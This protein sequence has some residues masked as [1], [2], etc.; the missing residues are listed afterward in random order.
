M[1]LALARLSTLLRWAERQDLVELPEGNPC[2]GVELGALPK[3]EDYLRRD[4]VRRLLAFR[5]P[6]DLQELRTWAMVCVVLYEG[7][8]LGEVRILGRGAIDGAAGTLDVRWSWR[9]GQRPKSGKARL[10]PLHPRLR[11][12]LAQLPEDGEL[13]FPGPGG[14]AVSERGDASCDALRALCAR[15]GVRVLQPKPWH[16][17]RHTFATHLDAATGGNLVVSQAMLGH[18]RSGASAATQAYLHQQEL[19]YLAGELAKLTY[20][21]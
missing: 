19:S 11:E 2:R 6:V 9:V 5:P 15:A 13:L 20:E 4:E 18:A 16:G 1:R 7:L 12:V 3:V 14:R 21:G 10:L 8:R 17:L